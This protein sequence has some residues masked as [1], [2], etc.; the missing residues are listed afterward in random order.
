M[1]P[2]TVGLAPHQGPDT[3]TTRPPTPRLAP[4]AVTSPGT[5]SEYR[6]EAAELLVGGYRPEQ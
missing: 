5:A 2:T 1:A 6:Q 4:P 3:R